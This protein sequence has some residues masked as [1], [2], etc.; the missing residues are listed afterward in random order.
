MDNPNIGRSLLLDAAL[1]GRRQ[2]FAYLL[3]LGADT[4]VRDIR[5]KGLGDCIRKDYEEQL[6]DG[7]HFVK[8]EFMKNELNQELYKY[9]LKKPVRDIQ[10]EPRDYGYI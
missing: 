3:N 6:R 1:K 4:E 2:L 5:G 10:Y 9:T 7:S 8:T